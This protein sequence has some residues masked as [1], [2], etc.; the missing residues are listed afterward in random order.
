MI[1][2]YSCFELLMTGILKRWFIPNLKEAMASAVSNL[3]SLP[4]GTVVELGIPCTKSLS[5]SVDII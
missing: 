2:F 4:V 5:G 3:I 1:V